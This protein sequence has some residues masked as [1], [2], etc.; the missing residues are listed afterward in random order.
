MDPSIFTNRVILTPKNEDVD[1][2]NQI[3]VDTPGK[4]VLFKSLDSITDD[5]CN[6]YPVEFLNTLC[7]GGM[8]LHELHIKKDCP[9]ILLRNLDPSSGLCNGTRLICKELFPNMIQCQI[10]TGFHQGQ[11]VL[12]PRII[13]RPSSS[14][15]YPFHF[16]CKQFPIKLSSVMMINKSQ[17]QTLQQVGIYL[18]EPCFS[19]GQLYV[20]LSRARQA[21]QLHVLAK[22][23]PELTRNSCLVRN[24]IAYEI[25]RRAGIILF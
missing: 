7:S 15:N 23:L 5:D 10:A 8:S 1:L 17:G 9:V 22:P 25:L 19:H 3:I 13:L 20:E 24:V 2:I 12:L 4:A 11:H 14:L 18:R 6:N 16:E 21:S